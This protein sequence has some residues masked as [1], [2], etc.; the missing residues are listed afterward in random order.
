MIVFPSGLEMINRCR[1]D[2][3][4][5]IPES[6]PYESD[7]MSNALCSMIT[8]RGIE[9]ND[10]LEIIIRDSFLQTAQGDSL[11]LKASDLG[12]TKNSSTA[13]SGNVIVT[14]QIGSII[15][16]DTLFQSNISLLYETELTQTVNTI[17]L[18]IDFMTNSGTTITASFNDPHN[19]ASGLVVEISNS[20]AWV[21]G[22]QT[23]SVISATE[24]Q[25]VVES[26]SGFTDTVAIL[27]FDGAIIPVKSTTVGADTNL[28]GGS[29]LTLQKTIT[30][31]NSI[32]YTQ[33][34]GID[35]GADIESQESLRSRSLY[36][37]QHPETPFNDTN[38]TLEALKVSGVT[39]VWI[40]QANEINTSQ[41]VTINTTTIAGQ[42]LVDMPVNHDLITGMYV[43]ITGANEAIFNDGFIVSTPNIINDDQFYIANSSLTGT[44]TGVITAKYSNV[45]EG[46]VRVFFVRDNDLNI[47]PSSQEITS[48]KDQI[49]TIKESHTSSKDIIV[50][51]PVLKVVDFEFTTLNP[52]TSGMR[53]SISNN[54]EDLFFQTSLGQTVTEDAYRT[55]IQNS[56]DAETRKSITNF[57]TNTT[58]D[59]TSLYNELITLGSVTYAL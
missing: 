56:F 18:N 55:A 57:E 10:Y 9:L 1:A 4:R 36:K 33:F 52:D 12:V 43:E 17:S 59:I 54:L 19:L 13:A 30:G 6:A 27:A 38:I 5:Y 28:E 8:N 34:F 50:D 14:G 35:G 15:P 44:A 39:R 23:I 51:G 22:P 45:Q 20:V 40:I 31:V 3:K 2:F 24:F 49:L 48:V 29:Q 37:N 53:D 46:Q 16:I 47:V 41:Q 58:G 25:F 7:S 32:A 42:Y 21:N 11:T 26:A